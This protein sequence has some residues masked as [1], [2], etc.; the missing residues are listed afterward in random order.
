MS[1]KNE[2]KDLK[3]FGSKIFKYFNT[4]ISYFLPV[5]IA[6]GMMFSFALATGTFENGTI[7]PSNQ[8][9]QDVYDI[10]QAGFAMMVP[11]LCAYIAYAI[12]SKPALA[13]GFILGYVANN[14]MGSQKISTGFLGALI[15]GFLVGYFVKWVKG[16]KVPDVLKPMMPTFFIPLLATFVVGVFY[17]YVMMTPINAF[18]QLI[19]SVMNNLNGTSV[20]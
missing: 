18:V 8:F 6:G 5:I 4:G 20:V 1:T 9:W 13:P 7:V 12:G 11:V 2:K 16:W 15:L 14:P 10:G 3:S 19:V 17:V